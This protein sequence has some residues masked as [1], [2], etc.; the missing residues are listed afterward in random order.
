MPR[1]NPFLT[2]T[3][4][5][6]FNKSLRATHGQ[7]AEYEH[8]IASADRRR[9]AHPR[10]GGDKMVA[11]ILDVAKQLGL[12]L[13]NTPLSSVSEAQAAGTALQPLRATTAAFHKSV[14]DTAFTAESTA[15]SGAMTYYTVLSRLAENDEH[16][17]AGAR[18][19]HALDA[20]PDRRGFIPRGNDDR[21]G[22]EH[23][24][25]R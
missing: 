6:K 18:R 1:K 13:P 17:R 2:V 12:D 3:L 9:M 10:P 5:E 4:A 25:R 15:W 14:A 8:L 7:F 20:A 19:D 21:Q 23:A 16:L 24:H 22:D 11:I